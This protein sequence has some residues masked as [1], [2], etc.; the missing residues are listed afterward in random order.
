M[1]LLRP[2]NQK[3]VLDFQNSSKNLS[4]TYYLGTT[5]LPCRVPIRFGNRRI[6][7]PSLI[8]HRL[9]AHDPLPDISKYSNSDYFSIK[10]FNFDVN[11]TI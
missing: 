6:F 4:L 8:Y 3:A 2:K 5:Y 7:Q 1:F 9:I 10:P 11:F